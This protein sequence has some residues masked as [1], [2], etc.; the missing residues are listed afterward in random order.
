M[1][2]CECAVDR[3]MVQR[4]LSKRAWFPRGNHTVS[5]E[6]LIVRIHAIFYFPERRKIPRCTFV[7]DSYRGIQPLLRSG[8]SKR[9][10]L[11]GIVHPSSIC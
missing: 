3:E 5:Y 11:T 10:H 9:E 7:H 2:L 6:A 1:L 4:G 8:R